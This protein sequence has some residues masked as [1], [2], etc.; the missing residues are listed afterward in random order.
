MN[1]WRKELLFELKSMIFSKSNLIIGILLMLVIGL[2][3]ASHFYFLEADNEMVVKS[4]DSEIL[5]IEN[6]PDSSDPNWL[7]NLKEQKDAL[8]SR[9][10]ETYWDKKIENNRVFLDGEFLPESG[11][12]VK[13]QIAYYEYLKKNRLPFFATEISGNQGF[14][15]FGR[16]M[17][18]FLSL[19]QIV[20]LT[21]LLLSSFAMRFDSQQIRVL[22]LYRISPSRALIN[23][24]I[25]ALCSVIG[26][27]LSTFI[28]GLAVW[29][30][31]FGL[32]SWIY[33]LGQ[34]DFSI[35]PIWRVTLWSL[36]YWILTCSFILSLG[37]LLSVL[38]RKSVLVIGLIFLMFASWSVIER[39]AFFGDIRKFFPFEYLNG[40][41]KILADRVAYPMFGTNTMMIGAIYLLVC[42]ILFTIITHVVFSRWVY[43]RD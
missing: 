12:L 39:K 6:H 13:Q 42:T 37:Q 43:R 2:Q 33:P 34:G 11:K 4:L 19:T 1:K 10:Y 25:V 35:T 14:T 3:F 21:V 30:S 18:S 29:S 32:G 41:S 7:E 5:E 36:L 15:V 24:F 9:D 23:H 26:L 8:L 27:V 17:A 20:L 22:H 38:L 16:L 31:K 40:V 28:L